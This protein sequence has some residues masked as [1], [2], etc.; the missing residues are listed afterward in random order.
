MKIEE[1]GYEIL[2]PIDAKF[3]YGLI[4]RIARTCYKSEN[5]I[6]EG[7]AERMLKAL[8]THDHMAMLEHY[9]ISVRFTT[10][11]GVANE[12]VRHRNCSFAQESTRYCR[13]D[14]GISVIKPP[15]ND[16]D[17]VEWAWT[18]AIDSV[19]QVYGAMLERGVAP[20]IARSIL[21]LSTKTEIVV[22]TN[23]REWRHIFKLRVLGTTGKPHPQI[24]SLLLPLLDEF[25]DALPVVF[26]DLKEQAHM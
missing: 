25:G 8:I 2:T 20:E 23:L 7:S 24:K 26:G 6:C 15:L 13:Y 1:Q 9:S 11:R 14:T 10:D 4:E 22:T 12:L 3:V 17:I 5:K 18:N 16:D 19:D 21:P